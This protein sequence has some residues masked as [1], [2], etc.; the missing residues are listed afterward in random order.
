MK[1]TL[2]IGA[3][4]VLI[5]I[6]GVAILTAPQRQAAH[7]REIKRQMDEEVHQFKVDMYGSDE[8]QEQLQRE[9]LEQNKRI[10]ELT[11][12]PL[13]AMRY[14]ICH[15]TTVVQPKHQR[16][17]ARLDNILKKM[18]EHDAKHPY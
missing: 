16:E 13:A 8:S 11:V 2:A 12:G 9:I 15:T 7:D 1:K 5:G 10:I 4:I 3:L 6:I 14:D 18:K 17:C